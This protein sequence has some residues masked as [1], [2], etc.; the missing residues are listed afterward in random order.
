ME[1]NTC[2]YV[3]SCSVYAQGKS[4]NQ[5]S[6]GLLRAFAVPSRPWSNI[7]LDFDIGLPPSQGNTVILTIVN[8]FSK[9]V[10]FFA[11]PNYP[12]LEKL[13]IT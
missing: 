1:E 12:V 5:V 8:R 9:A 2:D 3:P 10:H 4:S 11:L 13:P 7:S 6:A